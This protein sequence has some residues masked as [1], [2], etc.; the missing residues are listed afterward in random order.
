MKFKLQLQ[1]LADDNHLDCAQ[2]IAVF[3]KD[4]RRL[5]DLGLTLADS[6]QLLGELQRQL[7]AQQ[8]DVYLNDHRY[9]SHCGKKLAVKD[10]SSVNFRSLFGTVVLRSPRFYQCDCQPHHQ[11]TFSPL[12]EVLPELTAPELL[13]ME[14]KWASLMAYDVTA[15]RLKEVLPVDKTLNAET[16][17]QN[18]YK[19]AERNEAALDKEQFMFID[20]CPAQWA[21]LPR[22]D[23]P[24]TVGI[25]GGYIRDWDNKKTNFE[26]IVGKSLP[27]DS[28][29]KYFGLVQSYDEK[30]KR[31]LFEVL[32]SQGM[33][34]NQQITFLTDGGDTVRNLA[35]YL[36]PE[37]EHMLDWVHVTMRLTVLG[38][39]TKGVAKLDTEQGKSITKRLDSIKWYLWHGNVYEALEE[40][41][42]LDWQTDALELDYAHLGK[43]AK[44][45]REFRTYIEQNSAYIPNYGERY[46]N[47][48][49]ISTAFVESTVNTVVGKRFAK[50]QQMQWSHK[51]AHLLLQMRTRVLSGELRS[52]FAEWYPG[53]ECDESEEEI[54]LAA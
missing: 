27:R 2:D 1:M 9:C 45:V 8:I 52:K 14:T 26:V 4:Y 12:N 41:E 54:R 44:A 19:I 31:R 36:S 47:G 32:K 46:R 21:Q 51:G 15:E 7:V 34:E 50:K 30:P 35:L 42:D 29:D 22:P 25:D 10:Y 43:F 48:E 39:Y 28:A 5:A 33:Q 11:K 37:S 6:K 20:G 38:Q 16:I 18:L 53:F 17:R 23:G 40:I 24:I 13:Y 3:D 49:R